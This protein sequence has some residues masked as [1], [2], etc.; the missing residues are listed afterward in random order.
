M[1]IPDL[2]TVPEIS[3]Q[4]RSGLKYHIMGT[5][6]Q[7]LAVD[8]TP[9][10]TVYSDTGAM[11]WMTATV[12]M[13]TTTGGGLGGMFKRAIAGASAFIIDFTVAGGRVKSPLAPIFL[14]KSWRLNWRLANQSPSGAWSGNES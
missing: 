5:I 3:A 1:S 12:N 7:T 4:S 10:Q 2:P 11:S 13:N 9:G 6:Q 14:A 8:L